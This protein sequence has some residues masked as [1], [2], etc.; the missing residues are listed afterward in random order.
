[1]SINEMEK[2]LRSASTVSSRE[3]VDKVVRVV[4]SC[5]TEDSMYVCRSWMLRV[6]TEDEY[7]EVCDRLESK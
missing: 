6:L 7:L 1:M 5:D 2:L 3:K 4:N